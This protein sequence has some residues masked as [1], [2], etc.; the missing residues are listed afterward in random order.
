MQ[1]QETEG[2][3][4][5]QRNRDL[6]DGPTFSLILSGQMMRAFVLKSEMRQGRNAVKVDLKWHRHKTRIK[7]AQID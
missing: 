4:L 1:K 2:A 6:C 7:L 5:P 3:H